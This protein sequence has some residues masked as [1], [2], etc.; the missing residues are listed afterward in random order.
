[1][2]TNGEEKKENSQY[3]FNNEP[4]C[5]GDKMDFGWTGMIFNLPQ[6]PTQRSQDNA[7]SSNESQRRMRQGTMSQISSLP[8]YGHMMASQNMTSNNMTSNDMTSNDMTSNNMTSNN[9]TSDNMT[10]NNMTS[11]DMRTS[12]LGVCRSRVTR[13]NSTCPF[14]TCSGSKPDLA[15]SFSCS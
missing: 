9:M 14:N 10:S 3:Y 12:K 7:F 15:R 5:R 4:V 11:N 1:M 13:S 8:S 6:P 2:I